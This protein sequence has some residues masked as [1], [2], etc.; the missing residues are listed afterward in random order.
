MERKETPQ[1]VLEYDVEGRRVR[2]PWFRRET[3]IWSGVQS[4]V[5]KN[6]RMAARD[7]WRRILNEAGARP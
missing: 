5:M 3:C 2:R 6:W 7:T 4:F 1:E